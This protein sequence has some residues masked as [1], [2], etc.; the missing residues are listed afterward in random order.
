MQDTPIFSTSYLIT[1]ADYIDF[2]F[3]QR[4]FWRKRDNRILFKILGI[5]FVFLGIGTYFFVGGNIYQKICWCALIFIGLFLLFYYD[6]I[7]VSITAISAKHFYSINQKSLTARQVEL[8]SEYISIVS[9]NYEGKIPVKYIYKIVEGKNILIF[10]FDKVNCCFVPKRAISE[11]QL[12][13]FKSFVEGMSKDK[14][15][16]L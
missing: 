2:I 4:K 3:A 6:V 8:Y 11:E 16:K 7:D 10:Y 13:D 1:E 15:K 9:D 12:K 14:Y 5:L